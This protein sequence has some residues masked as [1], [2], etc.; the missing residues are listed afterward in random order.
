[1]ERFYGAP[2][3]DLEAIQK[4]TSA[5]PET[6]LITALNVWFGSLTGAE[7]FHADVHAGKAS[8]RSFK[9]CF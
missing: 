8:N 6:V 1:M 9:R 2:L 3:I 4:V 5:Q 7:T